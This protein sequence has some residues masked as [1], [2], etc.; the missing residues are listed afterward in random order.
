MLQQR[1]LAEMIKNVKVG[2]LYSRKYQ[3]DDGQGF[4]ELVTS[5]VMI[6]KKF[7]DPEKSGEWMYS[8]YNIQ[9]PEYF[10]NEYEDILLEELDEV[11]Y[12]RRK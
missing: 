1:K 3:E 10:W 2:R 8:L 4:Y 5:Y 9:E 12:K 7:N 11:K 6:T